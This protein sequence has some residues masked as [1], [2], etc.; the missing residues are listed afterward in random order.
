M[1]RD[2]MMK[3]RCAALLLSPRP[4]RPRREEGREEKANRRK[5]HRKDRT[6]T[7]LSQ[8]HRDKTIDLLSKQNAKVLNILVTSL[9]TKMEV[10]ILSSAAL[11]LVL[12][13]TL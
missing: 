12:P 4:R 3:G 8:R 6:A 7:T 9:A 1:A 10:C 2:E 5:K 11:L 13:Q